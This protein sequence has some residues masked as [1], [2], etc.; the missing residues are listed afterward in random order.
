MGEGI[1]VLLALDGVK[2]LEGR[3]WRLHFSLSCVVR[4]RL[5]SPIGPEDTHSLAER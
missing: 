4:R 2:S 1:V 3:S 5:H